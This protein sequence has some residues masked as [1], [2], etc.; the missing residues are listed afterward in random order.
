MITGRTR[1]YGLLGHPVR[2]SLSPAMHNELFRQCGIDAVYVTF[3]IDPANADDVGRAVR[4]L[5]LAGANLTVPFKE[6]VLPAL[7]VLGAE[8]RACGAVNVVVRRPDGALV[9]HNTD[10]IGWRDALR[11]E[12][13]LGLAGEDVA[14]LGAGGTGRAIAAAAAEAGA[15]SVTFY[16]ATLARAERAAETLAAHVPT[17]RFEALPL[18][19]SVF[20][21]RSP[22]H[23]RVVNCTSGGAA[24]RVETFPVEGL[25]DGALW[26]DVNYWMADPPR[27]A[28]CARRGLRIQRGIGML[29]H[30]GALSFQHFTGC[31][32]SHETLRG[33]LDIGGW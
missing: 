23:T 14:I 17:T 10:G 6:R 16:N 20:A 33:V 18:D 19:P 1:V 29:I 24:P 12:L 26:S 2:H 30:Q 7:D 31:E 32:V 25:P 5:G 21:E 3:E 4:T 13:G 22:G 28:A 27:L 8:A 9:G 11:A 15:A